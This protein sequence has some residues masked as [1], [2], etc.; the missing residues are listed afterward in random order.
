MKTRTACKYSYDFVIHL[1]CMLLV[2]VFSRVGA[3]SLAGAPTRL[4]T[5]QGSVQVEYKIHC[6][7][8]MWAFFCK[9][10]SA[11]SFH[12]VAVSMHSVF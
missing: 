11:V 6:T 7:S 5:V 12:T 8:T 9:P 3:R 1:H 4:S 2:R 10:M